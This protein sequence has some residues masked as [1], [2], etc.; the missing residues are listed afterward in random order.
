MIGKKMRIVVSVLISFLILLSSHKFLYAQAIQVDNWLGGRV[1]NRPVMVHYSGDFYSDAKVKGQDTNLRLIEQNVSLQ[2]PVW[3]N[4]QHEF[5]LSARM[6]LQDLDTR[7]IFP[8]SRLALPG[9]LWEI[10]FGATYRT[11]VKNDWVIGLHQ[12]VGSA[13]NKPFDTGNELDINTAGFLRIPHGDKNAWLFFLYFSTNR[14]FLN[15]IPLPGVGYWWEPSENFRA[16]L[17]IPFA[18]FTW[19]PT[20]TFSVRANYF[21]IRN[22]NL[23][24]TFQLTR[25]VALFADFAWR[26]Q[27]YFRSGRAN[28][29]DR[30]FYYEKR[31]GGGFQVDLI[32]QVSLQL[33]GG[34]AFDRFYFEA[35]NYDDR[36]NNLIDLGNAAFGE[37]R[38]SLKF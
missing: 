2:V 34:W 14:E 30:L 27:R 17:G 10:M 16:V 20:K 5:A 24:A 32:R 22:V 12:G 18:S 13:S 29:D 36:N 7:A 35:E 33:A 21:P 4:Q 37:V 25:P 38:V 26:N 9:D 11:V 6:E 1:G 3:Q 23:R 19:R 31:L 28:D 15:M 8:N